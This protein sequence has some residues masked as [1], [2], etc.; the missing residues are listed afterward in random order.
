MEKPTTEHM[1]VVKRVLGYI[2]GTMDLGCHYGRK[3]GDGDLVGYSDSDLAGDVDT[4]QSTI[5]V[6]FFLGSSL[7]T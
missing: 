4:R 5:G 3:K 1:I 2:A 7:I 6:L